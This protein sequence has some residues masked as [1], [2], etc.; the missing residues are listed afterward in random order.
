MPRLLAAAI[1]AAPAAFPRT[2]VIPAHLRHS[3]APPSF[4]RRRESMHPWTPA[5]AGVTRSARQWLNRGP[6]IS[7]PGW[8]S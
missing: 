5:Y 8:C 3:R 6:G 1:A 7:V 2:S 4:P